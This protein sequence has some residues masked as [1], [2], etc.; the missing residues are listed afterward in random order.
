MYIYSPKDSDHR[1]EQFRDGSNLASNLLG[2]VHL[3]SG[4]MTWQRQVSTEFEEQKKMA[5]LG[6]QPRS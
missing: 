6:Y 5:F 2:I 4:P 3:G 1:L